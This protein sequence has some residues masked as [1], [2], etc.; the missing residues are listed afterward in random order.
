MPSKN[1]RD[2][3]IVEE[4]FSM[5]ELNEY[6]YHARLMTIELNMG[7]VYLRKGDLDKAM[8]HFKTA[9]EHAL[10][11]S[12]ELGEAIAY[13]NEARCLICLLYTSPSPRDRG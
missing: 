6:Y 5:Q 3:R 13:V 9:R 4:L 7:R 1:V 11:I 12:H 10:N 8:R 2:K